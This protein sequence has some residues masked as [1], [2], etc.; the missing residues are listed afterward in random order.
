MD[1][2]AGR[3]GSL[4]EMLDW[5]YHLLDPDDQA[6]LRGVALF[7]SWFDVDDAIAVV[8]SD[9]TPAAMADGLAR[10]A[11]HSLLVVDRGQPTRYRVLETIRQYL[12]E[13]LV[14]NGEMP[15]AETRHEAW[16]C[17]VLADLAVEPPDDEW[18]G[19]FD[20]IVDDARAALVRCADHHDHRARTADARRAAGRAAVA[21][22][23]A[24][25][26]AAVVRAGGGASAPSPAEQATHLRMAAGVADSR[27]AGIDL[28]RL[29]R[30]AAD[31]ACAAGDRGAAAR[32]LA[33]MSLSITR[34]PGIMAEA[35]TAEDEAAAL[36][37]EAEAMS[38]GSAGRRRGDRRG[39]TRSA[40]YVG[41]TVEANERAAALALAGRRS[42]PARRGAGPADGAAPPA[43]RPAGGEAT[44]SGVARS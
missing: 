25:R 13:Q 14:A 32:D 31:V 44:R 38:D 7:A 16:C 35:R 39:A 15:A 10:L 26:G 20:R 42:R 34:S 22:R 12:E 24:R 27:F 33:W 40:D 17:A 30:R 4:R 1:G 29:L 28:L 37:A 36:L 19:R 5:S 41:L 3:H 43:R 8:A 18:C 21:A 23:T 6:L 9:R 11:D 2:S